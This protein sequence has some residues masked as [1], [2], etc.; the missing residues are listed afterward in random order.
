MDIA[1]LLPA[2]VRFWVY[3]VLGSVTAVEGV[4]DANDAGLIPHRPQNIA[5]GILSVLGF[6][7]AAANTPKGTR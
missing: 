5:L 6:A 1:S 2:K 4:L 7:L 3:T